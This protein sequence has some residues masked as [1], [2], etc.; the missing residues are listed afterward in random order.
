MN[1]SSASIKDQSS[2]ESEKQAGD[3]QDTKRREIKGGLPYAVAP[4]VFKKALDGIIVSE[5]PDRF[6]GHFLSTILN[7]TG[8]SS[9]AI[10]PLLKK[11][12]FLSSDGTPT[13]LYSKFKSD[14]ARSS[15]A[16]EGLRSA[17]SEMFRRNE[18][19]HKADE[20]K[21]VDLIVEITG[22]RKSDRIVGFI[23]QTFETIR[24]Y[25]DKSAPVSE[26][27]AVIDFPKEQTG[28]RDDHTIKPMGI[29]LSYN[30]NI[31]L[32]ESENPAVFNA[33]FRSLKANLLS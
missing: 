23:Y 32:P 4:G 18:F 6:S 19:I 10:P 5:R 7:L 13:E 1:E 16:L 14:S 30:I 33:I 24:A 15:A 3:K 11:M 28:S 8:G 27:V 20:P 22:L 29:G 25:I 26:G 31:I 21:V 2:G 17:F 9:R 12:N